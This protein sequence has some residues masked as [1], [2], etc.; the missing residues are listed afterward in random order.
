MLSFPNRYFLANS[1]AADAAV[2]NPNSIKIFLANGVSV[3]LANNK[4]IF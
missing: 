2:V 1:F 4:P 3:F